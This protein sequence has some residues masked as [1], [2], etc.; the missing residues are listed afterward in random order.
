M[1]DND[2]VNNS[3]GSDATSSGDNA[4]QHASGDSAGQQGA[5]SPSAQQG[6]AHTE[7]PTPPP[8]M[9]DSLLQSSFS[10]AVVPGVLWILIAFS[11]VSWAMLL[12]KGI[13]FSRFKS[14]NKRFSRQFWKSSDL[15]AS[16]EVAAS[17]SAPMAHLARTGNDV[18]KGTDIP[19]RYRNLGDKINRSDRLERSLKRQIQRERR[20]LES[21]LAI[22]ASIGST[23]PFIGL[24]GTV[25]GIMEALVRIGLTGQADLGSVAG[26]IGHAL[27]ATG[28]GIF[29]A[30][31]AVL[32]YNFFVRKLKLAASDLELFAEAYYSLAQ[33]SD[34]QSA[35]HA[36]P[37]MSDP[38][39]G[40]ETKVGS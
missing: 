9:G 21:G 31:P 18:V 27:I 38:T 13:Q 28:V 12:I 36:T 3:S 20:S 11:V 30:V 29:A 22:L 34:F 23:A 37:E 17:S 25:W 39:P 2:N 40:I 32:I 8:M 35:D 4:A 33:Q 19:E 24:F 10:G 15:S 26:P 1:A 7:Q 16:A 14:R 5:Q 6:A